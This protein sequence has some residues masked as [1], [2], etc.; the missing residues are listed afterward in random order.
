MP[1][2]RTLIVDDSSLMRKVAVRALQQAGL[3]IAEVLEAGNGSEA[4]DIL[5]HQ[6]V[7]LVVERYEHAGHGWFGV[8]APTGVGGERARRA[9]AHAHHRRQRVACD[10]S[11]LLRRCRLHPQT[12]HAR[13]DEAACA[14]LA[15]EDGMTAGPK[16][17]PACCTA[18]G[19][20][21]SLGSG[22]RHSDVSFPPLSAF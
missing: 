2:L 5:R 14:P 1:G 22:N 19:R 17:L 15:G 8:Y 13:P 4:L 7:D 20:S 3:A 6:R 18:T 21:R 9:G 11:D 12:L 16:V 10:G